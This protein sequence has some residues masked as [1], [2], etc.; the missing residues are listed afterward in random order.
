MFTE[1]EQPFREFESYLEREKST[2]LEK[3]KGMPL[4]EVTSNYIELIENSF[5]YIPKIC[6]SW[7]D[8]IK[9]TYQSQI[10]SA[11]PI[12]FAMRGAIKNHSSTKSENLSPKECDIKNLTN[13]ALQSA[14]DYENNLNQI[15]ADLSKLSTAKISVDERATQLTA[16]QER[17]RTLEIPSF[18]FP[19]ELLKLRIAFQTDLNNLNSLNLENFASKPREEIGQINKAEKDSKTKN[20]NIELAVSAFRKNIAAAFSNLEIALD[21]MINPR[22]NV[23]E[24]PGKVDL[25]IMLDQPT[26]SSKLDDICTPLKTKLQQQTEREIRDLESTQAAIA[27]EASQ[28]SEEIKKASE[29]SAKLLQNTNQL[30]DDI[31]REYT[32]II[33][34]AEKK[35]QE[36]EELIKQ[37]TA[38]PVPPPDPDDIDETPVSV[39]EDQHS[40]DANENQP[41]LEN[42]NSPVIS[43]SIPASDVSR[44][45]GASVGAVA[46]VILLLLLSGPMGWGIATAIAGAALAGGLIIGFGSGALI[47]R[48][49]QSKINADQEA[50][51]Q[52][53]REHSEQLMQQKL[54]LIDQAFD[55]FESNKIANGRFNAKNAEALRPTTEA[56]ATTSIAEDISISLGLFM[57]MADKI[58]TATPMTK[59]KFNEHYPDILIPDDINEQQFQRGYQYAVGMLYFYDQI[60]I[61]EFRDSI[62][63][64]AKNLYPNLT[65]DDYNIIF[66]TV[67][68][69]QS[70]PHQKFLNRLVTESNQKI[71]TVDYNFDARAESFPNYLS[72]FKRQF[73][74]VWLPENISEESYLSAKYKNSPQTIRELVANIRAE[75]ARNLINR[76]FAD[77]IDKRI[78]ASATKEILN[79]QKLFGHFNTKCH[80]DLIDKISKDIGYPI[81]LAR[82]FEL[83]DEVI[84]IPSL[85]QF[86]RSKNIKMPVG[87]TNEEHQ[88][89]WRVNWEKIAATYD[90]GL[91]EQRRKNPAEISSDPTI[92]RTKPENV[93]VVKIGDDDVEDNLRDRRK[94]RASTKTSKPFAESIDPFADNF[95]LMQF[96]EN[97]KNIKLPDDIESDEY[98]SIRDALRQSY[99]NKSETLS[100]D[101]KADRK[102]VV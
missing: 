52:K 7:L 99:K 27:E 86:T 13:S 98:N 76:P 46:F 60:S 19:P 81:S 51:E 42:N 54:A 1:L 12:V 36:I 91:E 82:I 23:P 92:A 25:G 71:Y 97:F 43:S 8:E 79:D 67:G 89:Q 65:S 17:A 30:I 94:E 72:D 87:L 68:H 14:I 41:L 75:Y 56:A 100:P 5:N 80:N 77:I 38:P 4:D 21:S 2:C 62:V 70:L 73:P 63:Y 93:P 39:I 50:N 37:I 78:Q 95:T 83:A 40:E 34:R 3:I 84:S 53:Q 33:T 6:R 48:A 58:E 64:L 20:E 9:K 74:R 45:T 90:K 29:D 57:E 11:Y 101:Q 35:R 26:F 69:D 96:K 55:I 24:Q 16:I 18:Q 102:S 31:E 66:K 15:H 44:I 22:R 49:E 88:K 47:D 32:S 85:Q 61:N 59:D 28:Y 10:F